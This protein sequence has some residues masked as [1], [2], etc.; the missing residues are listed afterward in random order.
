MLMAQKK[1]VVVMNLKKTINEIEKNS[2]LKV[3]FIKNESNGK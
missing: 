2:N 1:K 3:K